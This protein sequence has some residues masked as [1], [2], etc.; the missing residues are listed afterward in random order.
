MKMSGKRLFAVGGA[1]FA[2]VT[3]GAFQVAHA[4][5]MSNA[6]VG[7][8]TLGTGY[9][10]D[11]T[12]STLGGVSQTSTLATTTCLY[13]QGANITSLP[14]NYKP[15][16]GTL[17]PNTFVSPGNTLSFSSAVTITGEVSL[18]GLSSS[19][20]AVSISDFL[21]FQGSAGTYD[22]DVTAIYEYQSPTIGTYNLGLIGN[23]VD[24]SGDYSSTSAL[25]ILQ[26]NQTGGSG[27]ISGAYTLSS[28]PSFTPP[29]VP[30]PSTI[31]LLG[32]A[33]VGMGAVRRR[34]Q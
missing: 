2:A 29:T 11:G 8:S 20:E 18:V 30:E 25:A 10:G 31:A 34:K 12:G 19:P 17:A 7:G 21:T 26:V 15:A 1:V 27:A 23:L 32:G 4:T 14:T 13:F 24:Q 6:T 3:I 5:P 16:N 33:L 9:C 28:P 22:F